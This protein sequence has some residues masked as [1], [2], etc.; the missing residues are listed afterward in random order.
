MERGLR[1][2]GPGLSSLPTSLPLHPDSHLCCGPWPLGSSPHTVSYTE[3]EGFHVHLPAWY[4]PHFH[5]HTHSG[6]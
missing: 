1:V 5:L 3:W 2:S 4:V 6:T